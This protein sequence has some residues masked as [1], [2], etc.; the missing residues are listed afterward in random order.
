[1][2]LVRFQPVIHQNHHFVA[3]S[4]KI[5]VL[6]F[7][8]DKGIQFLFK[9]ILE[10]RGYEIIGFLDP[11]ACPL[12]EHEECRCSGDV[13]CTDIIISD[14]KMPHVDGISFIKG[15]LEKGCCISPANILVVSG[16][17]TEDLRK[18]ADEMG[19][20]VMRKPFGFGEIEEWLIG[21]ENRLDLTKKLINASE[22]MGD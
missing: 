12:H 18:D 17:W 11:S 3:M 10:T 21:C 7:E 19:V 9:K 2:G 8:D 16:Y 13:V 20:C 4:R 22:L 15:Q 5:R 6:V 1:M 14:I